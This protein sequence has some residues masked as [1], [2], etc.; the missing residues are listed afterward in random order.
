MN[1]FKNSTIL[2]VALS[3]TSASAAINKTWAGVGGYF[4]C[5]EV[6][7]RCFTLN[8]NDAKIYDTSSNALVNPAESPIKSYIV[9]YTNRANFVFQEA[10]ATL[11][12]TGFGIKIACDEGCTCSN[13][14]P[15]SWSAD[16]A[17]LNL[18]QGFLDTL[19]Q[20]CIEFEDNAEP[21]SNVETMARC[22]IPSGEFVSGCDPKSL[23]SS[24]AA[25]T[26]T[27]AFVAA[28]TATAVGLF[29]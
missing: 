27:L 23:E 14:H 26:T 9:P 15:E 17:G 1:V 28:L 18:T 4:T 5:P 12:A 3:L 20:E 11:V 21:Y 16:A 25:L 6:G 24:S 29:H 7:Q 13:T 19:Q 2:L 10:N 22:T 8:G